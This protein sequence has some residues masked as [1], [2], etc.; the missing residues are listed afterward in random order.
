M[1]FEQQ[2]Y[3]IIIGSTKDA[4][5][6]P[7]LSGIGVIDMTCISMQFLFSSLSGQSGW[8]LGLFNLIEEETFLAKQEYLRFFNNQS[9]PRFKYTYIT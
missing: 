1:H 3:Y 5:S 8:Y 2:Y 4:F 9:R 6:L 7:V